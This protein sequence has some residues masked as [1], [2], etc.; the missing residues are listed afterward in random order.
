ML[1][2]KPTSVPHADQTTSIAGAWRREPL[3]PF[4]AL[5]VLTA[6]LAPPAEPPP[7]W[8]DPLT[9][10]PVSEDIVVDEAI[11]EEL[12]ADL[13]VTRGRPPSQAEVELAVERWIEQEML[14][15]E[16]RRTRLDVGD[17]TLRRHL[18]EK[19]AFLLDATLSEAPP[20]DGT[21]REM[22]A[23]DPSAFVRPARWTFR[24]LFTR[25][26]EPHAHALLRRVEDGED[27]IAVTELGDPPPGGPVLRHRTPARL[28]ALLGDDFVQQLETLRPGDRAV[29]SSTEGWHVVLVERAEEAGPISFEEARGRLRLRWQARAA[30]EAR[31]A[32]MR[33][34]ADRYQVL[35]WP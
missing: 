33:R 1:T 20:D 22:F 28:R 18:A 16:A 7:R 23:E 4:L 15:R 24:H 27:P 26:S 32:A 19:M 21:L 2:S 13:D 34:L 30:E 8:G 9:P 29:L 6:T 12:R 31:Q 10:P 35:G 17:A 3:L 11:I 5:A 14:V 25:Q